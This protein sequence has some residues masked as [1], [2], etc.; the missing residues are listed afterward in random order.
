VRV[1]DKHTVVLRVTR[2]HFDDGVWTATTV[3]GTTAFD[4]PAFNGCAEGHAKTA[5]AGTRVSA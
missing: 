1:T 4:A 5:T 3:A 2:A